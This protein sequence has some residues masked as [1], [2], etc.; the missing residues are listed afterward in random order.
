MK[1]AGW[2]DLLRP[3]AKCSR[4]TLVFSITSWDTFNKPFSIINIVG[5]PEMSFF[6]PFIFIDIV[7]I[8]N[9]YF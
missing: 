7:G 3:E 4:E 1:L 9:V 5:Y 6:K 2:Q 8:P